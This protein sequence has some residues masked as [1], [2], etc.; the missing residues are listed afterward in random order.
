M[1]DRGRG[2]E[3]AEK[4]CEDTG[5]MWN[6]GG[7]CQRETGR[8]T[9]SRVRTRSGDWTEVDQ[10]DKEEVVRDGGGQCGSGRN[11]VGTLKAV[12]IGHPHDRKQAGPN[13]EL[14]RLFLVQAVYLKVQSQ[15]NKNSLLH[16]A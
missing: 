2:E 12:R 10:A 6:E 7:T 8:R 3:R 15:N 13:A 9:E 14:E 5:G 4:T 1:S 16:E 11:R